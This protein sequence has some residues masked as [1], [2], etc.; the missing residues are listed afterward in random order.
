MGAK[1]S[2]SWATPQEVF[3][4][5]NT[6]YGPFDLDA[7]ASH[8]NQM[9]GRYCTPEG[10]FSAH[11]SGPFLLYGVDGLSANW[12]GKVWLNPPYS[13]PYPWIKKASEEAAKGATVVALINWDHTTAY[14]KEFIGRPENPVLPRNGVELFGWPKR[15][16][17]NA[18]AGL[19]NKHGKPVA[20]V[21]NTKA[22]V[23][24]VFRPKVGEGEAR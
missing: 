15:V 22:S 18:P 10:T 3:D 13:D 6:K 23:V 2:D 4:V 8:D 16:W 9:V 1:P 20:R 5:L 12:V 21:G 17:F 19:L 11:M 14:W 24:V 7:A